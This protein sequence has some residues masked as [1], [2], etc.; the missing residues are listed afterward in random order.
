[1]GSPSRAA[2]S[3]G[4]EF[5]RLI[6]IIGAEKT[7]VSK[8]D[9]DKAVS[10]MLL[11]PVLFPPTAFPGA[12]DIEIQ[13]EWHA[14]QYRMVEICESLYI[15]SLR[16]KFLED[17]PHTDLDLLFDRLGALVM[18]AYKS[19]VPLTGIPAMND[20]RALRKG[21]EQRTITAADFRGGL[22][23]IDLSITA[24]FPSLVA[25]Y[26]RAHGFD[27]LQRSYLSSQRIDFFASEFV[28]AGKTQAPDLRA[29]RVSSA[30]SWDRARRA[31]RRRSD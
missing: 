30:A 27:E 20:L 9:A 22:P 10:A 25:A 3:V 11:A 14:W 2:Q 21:M 15:D 12:S 4:Q 28:R 26:L 1:M 19:K 6:Q 13:L 7:D 24:H 29:A 8:A 18:A 23:A 5:D 17:P 31:D 16:A